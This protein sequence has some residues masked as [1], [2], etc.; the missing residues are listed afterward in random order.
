MC[1][2]GA[3]GHMERIWF[4][5]RIET[6]LFTTVHANPREVSGN[7]AQQAPPSTQRL[8]E[9]QLKKS[10]TAKYQT[11]L[12]LPLSQNLELAEYICAPKSNGAKTS[13]FS[14]RRKPRGKKNFRKLL[15]FALGG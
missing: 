8:T 15:F 10:S 3:E 1:V 6:V 5:I 11:R 12:W 9:C 13:F 4:Q 14:A 2:Q 7:A